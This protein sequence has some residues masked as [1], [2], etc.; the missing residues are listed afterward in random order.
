M[1]IATAREFRVGEVIGK[2]FQV[3]LRNSGAFAVISLLLTLPLFLF[4][5]VTTNEMVALDG[6]TPEQ[7]E[8]AVWRIFGY[9]FAAMAIQL[10]F[11]GMASGAL[12][13]GTV[14]DLRGRR[15]GFGECLARGLALILPVIGVSIVAGIA[16]MLGAIL[17]I[18]PGLILLL[19]WWV[20]VPATV[21]ERPGIFA[22][23]KRSSFLTKGSRWRIFGM[24]LI[25]AVISGL[26]TFVTQLAIVGNFGLAFGA[27]L[28]WLV[29]AFVTALSAVL[30]AVSYYQLRAAKEGAEID[31]IARVFD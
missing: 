28:G 7:A 30:A 23:L 18:V 19:M 15:A 11:S 16:A 8:G 21:I 24:L 14:Q 22:S 1:A 12:T 20:A 27:F 10:V 9:T 4:E 2:G 25:V 29:N 31:V 17:F 13:Y 5:L 26:L 3:L 6:A